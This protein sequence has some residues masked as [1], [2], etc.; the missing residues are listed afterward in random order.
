MIAFIQGT[1]A[2]KKPTEVVLDVNGIGYRLF[3][4]TS[5]FE[6]LPDVAKQ[7][8]LL[9]HFHVREDAQVLFGFHSEG[10]RKAFEMMLG[11]TGIGPRLALAAL[12]AM[13]PRELRTHILSGDAGFL[14]SIPG[15]GRKTAERLIV[16]L[17]D[18]FADAAELER[19]EMDGLAATAV[20]AGARADALAAMEQ[21]GYSRAAAEKA[22]RIVMKKHPEVTSADEL[23]RRAL[24]EH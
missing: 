14:T 11:V 16:E 13:S 12:S 2:A 17:R 19:V 10:E 20:D 7:V 8:R 4:P 18:R 6:H 9:T 24:R 15:V 21:L 23:V 3:I 1:L 5:T 22:I